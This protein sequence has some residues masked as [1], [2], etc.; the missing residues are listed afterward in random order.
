MHHEFQ[1]TSGVVSQPHPDY[2]YD[3]QR[4]NVIPT[5][6]FDFDG[7]DSIEDRAREALKVKGGIEKLVA[8]L[9]EEFADERAADAIARLVCMVA[10]ARDPQMQ[11]SILAMAAGMN[12][13]GGAGGTDLAAKYGCSKQNISQHLLAWQK[14]LGLKPGRGQRTFAAR[15]SMSKSYRERHGVKPSPRTTRP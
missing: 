8:E 13:E 12:S 14:A 15:E 3:L 7:M 2:A 9:A 10:D 11:I 1:N 4:D 6:G 5:E